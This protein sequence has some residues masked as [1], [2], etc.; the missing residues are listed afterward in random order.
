MFVF[1]AVIS[2]LSHKELSLPI[3]GHQSLSV[4]SN[5][6]LAIF[7]LVKRNPKFVVFAKTKNVGKPD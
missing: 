5:G 3:T 1:C 4:Y 7:L 6:E 2:L